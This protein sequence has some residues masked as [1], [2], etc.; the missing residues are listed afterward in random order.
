[1]GS[2][3]SCTPSGVRE[4]EGRSHALLPCERRRKEGEAYLFAPQHQ[5]L[6]PS[7][8]S[9]L[10]PYEWASHVPPIGYEADPV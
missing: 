2:S 7:M 5:G 1:M 6:A 10:T 3:E 4:A 8:A 9:C